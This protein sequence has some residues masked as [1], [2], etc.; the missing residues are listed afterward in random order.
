MLKTCQSNDARFLYARLAETLKNEI[1]LRYQPGELLPTQKALAERFETSLITV[2]RALDELRRLG[3]IESVQ[4]K[5]TIVRRPTVIDTHTGVSSWTDTMAGLGAEPR[6]AWNRIDIERGTEE[7]RR[8]LKLKHNESLV[9]V[10]RLRTLADEPI[11]L[12]TNHISARLAPDLVECGL[13]EES[14]YSVLNKRFGIVLAYAD[15]EVTARAASEEERNVFGS[16]CETVLQIKRMSFDADDQPMEYAWLTAPSNRYTYCVRV[17]AGGGVNG[18]SK[19][20]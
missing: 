19:T 12:M 3:L 15:E 17:F 10:R 7:T 5:G 20:N 13:P 9:V 18:A 1:R 14:L 16:D 8:L 6:T 4:G 11:C 2:K